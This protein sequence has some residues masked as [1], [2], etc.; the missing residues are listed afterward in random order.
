MIAA[1]LVLPGA[2]LSRWLSHPTPVWLGKI[3]YG[4]YLWHWPVIL[5]LQQLLSVGPV[6]LAVLAVPVSTGLAALSF[7]VF[8]S[9]I[10]RSPGW[11]RC[12]GRS[13][14]AAS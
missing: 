5:V 10:R 4:T 1:C 8:E 12:T 13:W 7:Q 3:S 2:W 11:P 9:P 14:P 6:L